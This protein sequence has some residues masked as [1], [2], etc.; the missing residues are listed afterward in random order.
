MWKEHGRAGLIGA[1]LAA[2]LLSLIITD[3]ISDGFSID[4]F[5]AWL[6]TTVIV[7]AG[8]VAGGAVAPRLGAGSQRE[9]PR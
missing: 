1:A 5:T 3:L 4:G 9:L 6:L 8:S 2:T 7:W